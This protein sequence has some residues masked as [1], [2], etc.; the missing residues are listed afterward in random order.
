MTN[1]ML[2]NTMTVWTEGELLTNAEIFR[3]VGELR[4]EGEVA[5][6]ATILQGRPL[7]RWL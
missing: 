2:G 1:L 4:K 6:L 7:K 5:Q 3:R